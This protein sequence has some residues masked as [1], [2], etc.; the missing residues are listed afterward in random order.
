MCKMKQVFQKL[1]SWYRGEHIPYTLQEMMDLQRDRL[2][3]L[4]TEHLPERFQPPLLAQIINFLYR[5]WLRRWPVLLPVIVGI[6]GIIAILF[7]HFD[8]KSSS[9]TQQKHDQTPKETGL[10][11]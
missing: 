6:L 8:S 7:I 1:K 11:K 4:R 10:I 5:F 3:E 2:S 9:E